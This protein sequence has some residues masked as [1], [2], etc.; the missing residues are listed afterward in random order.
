MSTSTALRAAA[1]SACLALVPARAIAQQPEEPAPAAAAAAAPAPGAQGQARGYLGFGL[2]LVNHTLSTPAGDGDSSG[3]GIGGHGAGHSGPINESLDIGFTGQVAIMGRTADET[4]EDLADV[5]YEVDGGLRI[6]E[7]LYLT[8][9]YTTQTTAYDTADLATTYSVIPV[10][11]GIL[12]T[13]ESGYLLAQLRL[14]G[15]R[16]TNDQ[17]DSSE[18]VGYAGLR[19]V[20]QQ[21]A[22]EGVHFMLA[23]GWDR[24]DI[25]DL[26]FQDDF[27]R[28]DLGLGFGL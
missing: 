23:V 9:G 20:F 12:R 18:S 1:V 8:L 7:L 19:G 25:K 13:T 11:V 22:A 17:D 4:D 27:L 6:S 5:M 3:A 15:G 2:V 28:I 14:G 16:I 21:G 24:Y 26:D 10:G